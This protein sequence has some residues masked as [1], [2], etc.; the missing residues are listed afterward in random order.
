MNIVNVGNN[1]KALVIATV[2]KLGQYKRDKEGNPVLLSEIADG[3]AGAEGHD[4]EGQAIAY[5]AA[6]GR[7]ANPVASKLVDVYCTTNAF[8]RIGLSPT[9]QA[10]DYPIAANTTYRVPITIGNKISAI[11]MTA[12]GTMYVHEV[13]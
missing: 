2:D 4:G 3:Y 1:I 7:I 10:N 13:E 6:H 8:I 9:A 12:D 5:T 11:R